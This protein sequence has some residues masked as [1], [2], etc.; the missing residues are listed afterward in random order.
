MT[1]VIEQDGFAVVVMPMAVYNRV[2]SLIEEAEDDAADIAAIK[3]F[4]ANDDGFR[5]PAAV[6]D[7]ELAGD[8][9]L[10]AW[11][12]YRRLTIADLVTQARVSGPYLS[13]IENRKRKGGADVFKRLAAVLDVPVDALIEEDGTPS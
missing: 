12:T 2:R 3:E 13:Q 7:A 11:R 4:K 5:V 10:K 9:P 6:L 8:H 1:H